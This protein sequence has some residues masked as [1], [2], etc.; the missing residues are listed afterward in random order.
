Q[1]GGA[2]SGGNQKKAVL[3]RSFLYEAKA[4]LIDEPTQGVDA[5]AR[6]DIYR[7][8]RAK[9]DQGIA[10]VINSSDAMELS[11]MCDRVLVFSRGRIIRELKGCEIPEESTVSSFLRPKE[12]AATATS[13]V[14]ATRPSWF[15]TAHLRQLIA[16]GSSQWWVPLLFLCLLIIAVGGYASLRTD[17][18]FTPLN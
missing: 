11:G 10:C 12:V 8:I 4:L 13:V 5:K 7:A 9:A 17:V 6:F 3:S 1:P 16:G 18:F 15:S 2:L 14:D